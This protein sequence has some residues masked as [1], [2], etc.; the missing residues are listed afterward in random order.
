M[1]KISLSISFFGSVE[2][3]NATIEGLQTICSD[4]EAQIVLAGGT[5]NRVSLEAGQVS[6]KED[7]TYPNDE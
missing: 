6:L 2:D 7:G 3:D 1:P 5:V 4:L